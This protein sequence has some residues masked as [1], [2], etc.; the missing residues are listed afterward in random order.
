MNQSYM[1]FSMDSSC[2]LFRLGHEGWN[3][4]IGITF[5]DVEKAREWLFTHFV[6]E[7]PDTVDVYIARIDR[8]GM[9][10]KTFSPWETS[11]G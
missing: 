2:Q 11:N 1:I 3:I 8:N 10:L 9:I 4:V 7:L 6:G 5:S